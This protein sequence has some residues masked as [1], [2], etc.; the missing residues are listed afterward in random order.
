[1]FT[2]GVTMSPILI[3]KVLARRMYR[4]RCNNVLQDYS[5]VFSALQNTFGPDLLHK[6]PRLFAER[7]YYKHI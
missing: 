1:M 3:Q 2:V 5:G 6:T 4:R 7:G